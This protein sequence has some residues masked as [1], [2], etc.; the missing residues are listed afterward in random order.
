MFKVCIGTL[1]NTR[2]K[3]YI[4]KLYN[5]NKKKKNASRQSDLYYKAADHVPEQR[6]LNYNASLRVYI[7]YRIKKRIIIQY[8]HKK[9]RRIAR[10]EIYF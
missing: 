1:G 4:G 7:L 10:L 6:K 3:V 8:L 9:A 2:F 5:N